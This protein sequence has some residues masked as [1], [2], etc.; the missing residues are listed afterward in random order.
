MIML[1]KLAKEITPTDW[2]WDNS[3]TR[4]CITSETL[5]NRFVRN[6]NS[7]C[8]AHGQWCRGPLGLLD[9]CVYTS[10]VRAWTFV[11]YSHTRQNN[12]TVWWST[13]G[14]HPHPVL[15]KCVAEFCG[16]KCSVDVRKEIKLKW[17]LRAPCRLCLPPQPQHNQ[18]YH[19]CLQ[20]I[21]SFPAFEKVALKKATRLVT[22][23]SQFLSSKQL[24]CVKNV[25]KWL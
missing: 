9:Y 16:T 18:N 12:V 22:A 1:I 11:H 15:R 3:V 8:W 24:W 20:W 14:L 5:C 4:N 25:W 6:T 7:V 10:K 21:C 17:E 13:R 23:H 19:I 2:L